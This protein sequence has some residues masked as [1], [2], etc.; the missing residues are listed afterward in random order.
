MKKIVLLSAV[1][2][3][4]ALTTNA[5]TQTFK[6]MTIKSGFNQD[7]ICEDKDNLQTSVTQSDT[8]DLQGIDGSGFVFYTTGVQE[9]GAMCGADGTF[10]SS[11][12]GATFKVN[13]VGLNALVLKGTKKTNI[14]GN[15]VQIPGSATEGTLEFETPTKAKS[16]YVVGTSADGDSNVKVTVNYTD[17]TTIVDEITMYNWDSNSQA[18]T[19]AAVVRGLGRMASKKNWAGDAG[20]IDGGMNFQLFESAINTDNNKTIKSVT[21]EQTSDDRSV[22]I[23][24][25]STS[26]DVVSDGIDNVET[27]ITEATYYTLDGVRV[28]EPVKGVN[29]VK[30]SNGKTKKVIVN[31]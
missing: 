21:V 5:Q 2:A 12:T 20:K 1:L 11:R 10:K 9:T 26:D 4:M 6:H 14:G 22:A 31:K 15:S 28:K 17:N 23:F 16:I 18:A 3:G 25:V 7:V 24:A 13:P 30:M 27:G 29:I 19:S 8:P